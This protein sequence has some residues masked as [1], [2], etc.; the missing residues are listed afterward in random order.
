MD[1]VEAGA[2]S[3]YHVVTILNFEASM[4]GMDGL[5]IGDFLGPMNHL[6]LEKAGNFTG[7]SR[8]NDSCAIAQNRWRSRGSCDKAYD[9]GTYFDGPSTAMFLWRGDWPW[10]PSC[11]KDVG[12]SQALPKRIVSESCRFTFFA[13]IEGTGHHFWH[14]LL[15]HLHPFTTWSENFSAQLYDQDHKVGFF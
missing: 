12:A 1:K 8:S 15:P 9:S 3:P 5:E 4:D 11:E 2:W 6:I 14:S 10:W 13:G 7:F